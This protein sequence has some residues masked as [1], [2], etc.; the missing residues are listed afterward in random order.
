[1]A[2]YAI[3]LEGVQSLQN[4]SAGITCS[5]HKLVESIQ[6][7]Y[8]TTVNLQDELGIYSDE[9]LNI[10]WQHKKTL[11]ENREDIMLLVQKARKKADEITELIAMGLGDASGPAGSAG[12][13]TG[14][15]RTSE[16]IKGDYRNSLISEGLLRE[17]DFGALDVRTV[18]DLCT[19]IR[20][21][22]EIFPDLELNFVGS[23]QARN[24]HLQKKLTNMYMEL[25]RQCNPD[26]SDSQLI[27]A[28]QQQVAED[29]QEFAPGPRTMA[30]SLFVDESRDC[31]NDL[32]ASMNGI[33]IN[34][35][36]GFNYDFFLV[37]RKR[38]VDSGRK[39]QNCYSPKATVDH[40]LGH[41]IDKLVGAQYDSDIQQL[42]NVFSQLSDSEKARTLSGYAGDNIQE[43]IAESWSEY[44]NN[45]QC[46]DYARM[47]AE[48]MLEL[49]D[50]NRLKRIRKL[51]GSL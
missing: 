48:R 24:F 16:E 17:A 7:L 30:Q 2:K 25:Y 9:I 34:E 18:S 50:S 32:I 13:A 22:K 37:V 38:E 44:R 36:C 11:E 15:F 10:V 4:L 45:P 47:V 35:A 42:Y 14:I 29:L 49:Y 19:A 6:L 8:E 51:G 43:F 46:R 3:S 20:E 23:I 40:E 5:V 21:T 1:M 26:I 12:A 28:V 31:M 41:Q 27:T 33:T 39:P